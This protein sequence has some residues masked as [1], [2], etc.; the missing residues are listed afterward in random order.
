VR[1]LKG[2]KCLYAHA[3]YTEEEFWGIYDEAWYT[4]L[5]EKWHATSLPS[6]FDKVR[7]DLTPKV[8]R[9]EGW[10]SWAG[11]RVWDVWPLG[12]VYG[13]LSSLKGGEFLLGK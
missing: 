1:E 6:V 11:R 9:D 3:Y 4:A 10:V 5:R 8:R 12:G 2:L 7:V 13:V